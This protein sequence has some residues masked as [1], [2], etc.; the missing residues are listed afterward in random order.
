MTKHAISVLPSVGSLELLRRGIAPSQAKKSIVAFG[1]AAFGVGCGGEAAP[2]S[3]GKAVANGLANVD[4]L[5]GR[6]PCLDGTH[7]EVEAVS[8]SLGGTGSTLYFR[9]DAT[10]AAVKAEAL[11]DYRV[12]YFATHGLIADEVKGFTGS[13]AEPALAF[14]LP[15]TA[16]VEDDG[17]LTT[18]EVARLKLDADWVVLSACNTA[19]SDALGSVLG[20]DALSGFARAFIHAGARSILVSHWYVDDQATAAL[21]SRTFE[22]AARNPGRRGAEALRDAMLSVWADRQHPEWSDPIYWAPFVLVG[23]PGAG[24]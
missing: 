21:M 3:S 22:A 24:G 18:A 11:D 12:V 1:D 8:A 20:T 19:S 2:R 15:T 17:L 4:A 23:E 14:T 7:A 9:A 5:R 16:T 10:E 6:L 13:D